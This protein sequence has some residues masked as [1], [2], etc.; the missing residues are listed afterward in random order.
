M[1]ALYDANISF[2]LRIL[3]AAV[4]GA[5]IG[6]ERDKH[7]RAAGLRTHLL[8]SLGA[9]VFTVLSELIP[10]QGGGSG[11]V[12]DPGRIAAQIVTGIGFL[13]A[14]VIIKNSGNVRGLT[15]AACLWTAAAVGMA[16]GSNHFV[17]AIATTL[18]ALAGLMLLKK[19][20]STYAK[21][22]YR[23][24]TVVTPI[25]VPASR[26]IQNVKRR[27]L[28]ILNCDIARDFEKGT[29]ETRLAI[30]IYHKGTTDKLAHGIIES[31]EASGIV[32]KEVR[33]SRT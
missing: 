21:D 14:G 19:F 1:T 26:I 28:Q 23:T 12:A 5:L 29:N 13:G 31:L 6:L 18:L 25:D 27:N 15:T 2:L 22:S 7:G 24:L 8:V 3:V 17:L 11:Y 4:L 10:H 32:L 16:C 30:Q 33:W 9:A 20:E